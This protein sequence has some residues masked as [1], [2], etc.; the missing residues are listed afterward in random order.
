MALVFRLAGDRMLR[1]VDDRPGVVGAGMLADIGATF[2]I[3]PTYEPSRQARGVADRQARRRGGGVVMESRPVGER[4][5]AVPV[6]LDDAVEACES[7]A[8]L[9]ILMDFVAAFVRGGADTYAPHFAFEEVLA[10][11]AWAMRARDAIAARLTP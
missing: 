10:I 9:L 7:E 6:A 3:D 11:C 4:H 5:A 1:S 8:E 2:T